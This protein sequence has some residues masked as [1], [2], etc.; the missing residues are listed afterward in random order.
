MNGSVDARRMMW[1][2]IWAGL[3]LL[4]VTL[5]VSLLSLS[6]AESRSLDST[7]VATKTF[8]QV[9]AHINSDYVEKPDNSMLFASAVEG[10]AE[11]LSRQQIEFATAEWIASASPVGNLRELDQ[12]F[13][14]TLKRA[15][16]LISSATV[17]GVTVGE[18][19]RAGVTR[20]VQGLSKANGDA[21]SY[22]LTPEAARSL[23]DSLHND[24]FGGVGI[25]IE[26][27]ADIQKIL[28]LSVL[29]ETPGYRSGLKAGDLIIELDGMSLAEIPIDSPESAKNKIRGEIGSQ[30][31]LTVERE[32][33]PTPLEFSVVRDKV[34]VK[35]TSK[36]DL[37][38]SIGYIRIANFTEEAAGEV[39]K[40]LEYFNSAA[41]EGLILDLRYNPG[42]LLNAAV[43]VSALFLPGD[44]LITYTQG[45]PGTDGDAKYK[46]FRAKTEEPVWTRPLA[47]LVNRHSASASE[48]VTGAL[49]DHG[50]ARIVGQK[51][52]GKG[53]VQE[54]FPLA[55]FSSLRLTVAYYFT[56]NG[57]CIHKIGIDPDV[58][59]E[60]PVREEQ[61]TPPD[62]EKAEDPAS[63][64]GEMK[65]D[66]RSFTQRQQEALSKD[67]VVRAALDDLK[68]SIRG[69]AGISSIPEGVPQS[70]SVSVGKGI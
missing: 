37:E 61:E 59:V 15:R 3:L 62:E 20:M 57:I 22:Y 35:S 34:D 25:I 44:R 33:V 69:S 24:S 16:S 23:Q 54:I 52:F 50:R 29:P 9:A 64:T 30:L 41:T 32:G 1:R 27:L 38:D 8:R 51:T 49:K 10:V 39:R 28:I 17:E 53:S 46:E 70:E 55:D 48:I 14:E 18:L 65:I 12:A 45:R 63:A 31:I 47:V 4:C 67:P 6:L 7:F 13:F 60:L 11:A 56:P 58:A 42:G 5:T 2:R 26:Y 19:I 40:Y 21:Y 68:S 66:R 43:D 36:L